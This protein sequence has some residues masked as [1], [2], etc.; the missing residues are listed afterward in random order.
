M[1]PASAGDAEDA[2]QLPARGVD[3]LRVGNEA[4]QVFRPRTMTAKVSA[5]AC[6]ALLLVTAITGAREVLW[7][8]A[9][10]FL[11]VAQCLQRIEITGNHA[12]RTGLRIVDIDLSTARVERTGRAWWFELFFLGR[13][14]EL[15]DADRHGLLLESWLWSKADRA[16]IVDAARGTET[17]VRGEVGPH[18]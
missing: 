8:A 13:C 2:L 14:L 9:I 1:M 4:D 10:P 12:R 16:A 7:L 6:V 11:L 15:R 18:S 17:A 5:V 3:S